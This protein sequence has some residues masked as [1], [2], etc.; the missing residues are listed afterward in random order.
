MSYGARAAFHNR[1][2]KGHSMKPLTP[3]RVKTGFIGL[4]HMGNPI[5]RRLLGHGYQLSVYD[6]DPVKTQAIAE[7]GAGVAKNIIELART[8]DVLLSS[9]TNDEVVR[10]VYSGTDGVF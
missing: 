10:S 9:L 2:T 4:G 6:M 8:C 1:G 3:N 7:Q 5:A